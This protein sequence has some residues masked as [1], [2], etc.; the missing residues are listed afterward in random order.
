V[1]SRRRPRALKALADG[2]H[3]QTPSEFNYR[4]RAPSTTDVTDTLYARTVCGKSNLFRTG[5]D[6][7]VNEHDAEEAAMAYFRKE[8][9]RSA[10]H[11]SRD[12]A[13]QYRE[14]KCRREMLFE[15]RW[16]LQQHGDLSAP[17][18]EDDRTFTIADGMGGALVEEATCVP[19]PPRSSPDAQAL[20]GLRPSVRRTKTMFRL[21]N[22]DHADGENTDSDNDGAS[23]E[24]GVPLGGNLKQSSLR[25]KQSLKTRLRRIRQ[26]ARAWLMDRKE[27]ARENIQDSRRPSGELEEGE[28]EDDH[29]VGRKVPKLLQHHRPLSLIGHRASEVATFFSQ[30]E[31]DQQAFYRVFELYDTN[32]SNSLDQAELKHCLADLGLRGRNKEERDAIREVLWQIDKLEVGF[33]EFATKIVPEVRKALATLQHE[34]LQSQ[35]AEADADHSGMLSVEETIKILRLMGTFPNQEQVCDAIC[36]VVPN[37]VAIG[38]NLEGSWIMS[39]DILDIESFEGLMRLLQERTERERKEQARRIATSFGFGPEVIDTWESSIV[40]MHEAFLRYGERK[41]PA[42]DV[43]KVIRECGLMP[44]NQTISLS[45]L[46]GI[47]EDADET[48]SVDFNTFIG[49]AQK[50]RE[51]DR[52][53]LLKVFDKHDYNNSQ[54]LTLDEIY[55]ALADA[56]IR[57][58]TGHEAEELRALIDEFDEDCSGDADREEFIKLCQFVSEKLFRIQ[59]EVERQAGVKFGFTDKHFE[60]LRQAFT[61]FDKD[62]SELLEGDEIAQAIELL[63]RNSGRE[64]LNGA[65]QDLGFD[66]H[67]PGAK[68]CFLDFLKIMKNLEERESQRAYGK[69]LGFTESF[70]SQLRSLYRGLKPN[71]EGQVLRDKIKPLLMERDLPT[72]RFA[73]IKRELEAHP[74]TVGFE[75]FMRFM[76]KAVDAQ[77]NDD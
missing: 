2:A 60:E 69:R 75:V 26:N 24:E 35:F 17:L 58:R 33:Y 14:A 37:A 43:T 46:K 13:A 41:I 63:Q 50:L 23:V 48:G 73:E 31:Q 59:R 27:A 76:K 21:R 29:E 22:Y 49:I 36:D 64:D 47:K 15:L 71:E 32:G 11:A 39:R 66:T 3:P 1:A 77:V 54:G 34:K 51:H 9:A 67:G 20:K 62:M 10:Q 72:D 55:H 30:S 44:R 5:L 56:G 74:I 68:V 57:P 45:L 53:F 12:Q 6:F 19:P 42:A 28:H 18:I 16:A 25:P 61:T 65:M 38:K 52:Q 8:C 4:L 70:V 40:G 7:E